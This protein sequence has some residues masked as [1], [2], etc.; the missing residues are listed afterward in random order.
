MP[1]VV[2]HVGEIELDPR[3][4]QRWRRQSNGGED[5]RK[6]PRSTPQQK[7]TEAERKAVIETAN[8]PEFRDLSPKQIVPRL[9]D[10]GLYVASESTFY[11]V[12]RAEGLMAHRGPSKPRTVRR[13]EELVATGPNEVWSWDITYLPTPVRGTF[14]YLYL[15]VDVWS[16]RIMKAVVLARR[17]RRQRRSLARRRVHGARGAARDSDVA[18]RQRQPHEGLDDARHDA[19]PRRSSVVQS[20]ERQQ[21]QSVLGGALSHAEVRP[22]VP[23]QTLRVHRRRVG[24]GRA[25][26]R[27]GTTASTAT[28]PSVSSRPNERHRRA[29][30]PRPAR[31]PRRLRGRATT[32]PGSMESPP[33][34]LERAR[35]RGSQPARSSDPRSG[36]GVAPHRSDFVD[37]HGAG[38]RNRRL[39]ISPLRHHAESASP[40]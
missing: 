5:Q 18:L 32:A 35:H 29:R 6:G 23:A 30:R 3:T 37:E 13:P 22:V 9:A 10:R 2:W 20:T 24:V 14:F 19:V 8:A 15:F 34:P 27:H 11:R 36:D 7:L 12:L 31:T 33:A 21:R 38:H 40:A 1:S 26:R 17:E 4:V 25:I 16:R 39:S 28:A